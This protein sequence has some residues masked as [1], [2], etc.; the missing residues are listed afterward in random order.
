MAAPA[1]AA[2]VLRRLFWLSPM[3]GET[4]RS[5]FADAVLVVTEGTL[6]RELAVAPADAPIRFGKWLI[7]HDSLDDDGDEVVSNGKR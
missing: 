4:S 2:V 6:N 7:S 1:A 5:R 3:V